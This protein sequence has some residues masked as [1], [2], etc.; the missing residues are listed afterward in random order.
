M[1]IT[2]VTELAEVPTERRAI[3]AGIAGLS[4]GAVFGLYLQ[5][6]GTMPTIGSLVGSASL[7]A[8]WVVHLVVSLVFAFVFAA[9]VTESRLSAFVGSRGGGV[10]LGT[11]YGVVLWL[12]AGGLVFPLWL[13]AVGASAP[14]IPYLG[15]DFLAGHVLYGLVLGGLYPTITRLL[16]A[17]WTVP[18]RPS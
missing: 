13:G 6:G 14:P 9:A 17:E 18:D 16:T 10:V 7:A 15:M 1:A 3:G 11:F 2:D 4:A 8:G 12:V 5:A